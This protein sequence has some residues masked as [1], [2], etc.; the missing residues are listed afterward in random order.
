MILNGN[1]V[2]S[3]FKVS[4]CMEMIGKIYEVGIIALMQKENNSGNQR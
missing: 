3:I 2:S 4:G 1:H